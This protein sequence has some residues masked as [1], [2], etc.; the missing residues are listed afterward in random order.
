MKF[1]TYKNKTILKIN[2]NLPYQSF[3][4]FLKSWNLNQFFKKCPL[5]YYGMIMSMIM[6]FLVE[7]CS[8][9]K[10]LLELNV[11]LII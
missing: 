2:K 8:F 3:Q 5:L 1:Y 11:F 6:I 7:K 9:F 4:F 10:D